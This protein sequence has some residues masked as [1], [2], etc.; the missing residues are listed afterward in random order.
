MREIINGTLSM[1]NSRKVVELVLVL[2]EE[3]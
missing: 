2:F 1:E 3:N